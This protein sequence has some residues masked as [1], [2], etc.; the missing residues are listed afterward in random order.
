MYE[1][2]DGIIT[3]GRLILR[4]FTLDDADDVARMCGTGVIQRTVPLP[5]PYTKENAVS[6]IMTHEEGRVNRTANEFAVTD[7]TTGAL[8]GAIALY[9]RVKGSPTAELGYWIGEEY[10]GHGYATEASRGIIEYAFS[11]LL[12]HRV[13]ARHYGSNIAS[14]RVMQKVG[15]KYE[16]TMR[17]HL[18]VNGRYEDEVIYGIVS[19]DYD[20]YG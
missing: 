1:Y 20:T 11:E 6:W 4:P 2:K 17:D 19:M 7:K 10:W 16:G 8:Y 3:T 9:F 5:Y 14:G 13:F 15:M 18:F 12:L